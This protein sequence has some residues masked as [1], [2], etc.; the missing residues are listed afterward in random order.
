MKVKETDLIAICEAA[1]TFGERLSG[2]YVTDVRRT[3]KEE[4]AIRFDKWCQTAASGNRSAFEAYLS[5]IGLT[6]GE[7]EQLLCDV[8]LTHPE[9]APAWIQ[10]LRIA[11]DLVPPIEK[12]RFFVDSHPL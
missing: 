2:K 11:I 9:Q 4:I 3:T 7:A 12:P 8:R 10:F 5:R 1:S 6:A